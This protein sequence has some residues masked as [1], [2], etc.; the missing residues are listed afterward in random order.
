MLG[1]PRFN[2]RPEVE[3]GLLRDECAALLVD[4]FAAPPV[5]VEGR[6]G[7][8]QLQAIADGVAPPRRSG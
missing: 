3:G 5:T 8:E 6:S 7:L 4:F 1:E 2:H